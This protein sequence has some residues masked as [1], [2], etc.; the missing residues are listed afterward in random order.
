VPTLTPATPFFHE[1][2]SRVANERLWSFLV[3]SSGCRWTNFFPR[4][5]CTDSPLC[6]VCKSRHQSEAPQSPFPPF[7]P[8][9]FLNFVTLAMPNRL[10]RALVFSPAFPFAINRRDPILSFSVI[11]YAHEDLGPFFSFLPPFFYPSPD[12]LQV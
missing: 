1:V 2:P 8:Y 11:F 4:L 5:L 12:S 7:S 3:S 10:E 6:T 9:F